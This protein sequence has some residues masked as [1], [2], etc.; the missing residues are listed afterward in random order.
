MMLGG[1]ASRPAG[2]RAHSC[3]GRAPKKSA[4]GA[5]AAAGGTTAVSQRRCSGSGAAAAWAAAMT[6]RSSASSRPLWA[7]HGRALHAIAV[8]LRAVSPGR[9]SAAVNGSP[10]V[11]TR[12]LGLAAHGCASV[13]G[14]H[15]AG[16]GETDRKIG[17]RSVLASAGL[18][19]N[20]VFAVEKSSPK[21]LT[22]LRGGVHSRA[23]GRRFA[24]AHRCL[25]ARRTGRPCTAAPREPAAESAPPQDAQASL[26]YLSGARRA[27]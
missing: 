10:A 22:P 18:Q 14:V 2:P 1:S 27:A 21:L 16:R 19:Y 5:P 4:S 8:M 11:V 20:E 15:G 23:T 12:C 7:L 13:R 26:Q 6:A 25:A 24:S 17:N 3:D 9:W